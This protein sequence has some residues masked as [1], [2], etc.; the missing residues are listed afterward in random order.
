MTADLQAF[1]DELG[2]ERGLSTHTQAAYRRDLEAF[3]GFLQ[4]TGVAS[5][6]SVTRDAVTA[7]LQQQRQAGLAA[8]TAA[9]RLV[10]IKVFFRFLAAEG[11]IAA[12]VTETMA[13][14]KPERR[15]P[16]IPDE[17]A[18]ARLLDGVSPDRGPD[19]PRAAALAAACA[20]RDRAAVELFYACGLRVSELAGLACGA[21][22]RDSAVVRCTGKGSKERVI[23]VGAAA[24]ATLDRYLAHG[25][26][27]LARDGTPGD[28]LFV[29]ARGGR[30]TRQSLWRLVVKRARDA[31]LRGR[32]TPHTLRHC[33]ASHLLEHG[34]DLRSI[35]QLL[36]HADIAT[37]Q[38]YTHVERGR[39]LT[40]H[41]EFH[42]RA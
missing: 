25:R 9:R 22:D 30:F 6:G 31:G 8:A 27:V 2:Y 17:Q 36:G 42:P 11:R 16:R 10:A 41:R 12:D 28:A 35:Q 7:F 15:L 34:A 3:A 38:V 37:T 1:L 26:T 24:L 19:T 23:P 13:S 40:I 29:N 32:V 4:R 21:V 14:P 5:W 18:V 39:L 33:F 20:L